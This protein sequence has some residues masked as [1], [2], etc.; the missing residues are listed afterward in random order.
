MKTKVVRY[1]SISPLF[2]ISAI[3]YIML[4]I[5]KSSKGVNSSMTTDVGLYLDHCCSS[6]FSISLC[7]VEVTRIHSTIF[8]QNAWKF[9]Y[10][11]KSMES[12]EDT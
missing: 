8:L 10:N 6:D 7:I 5:S 2:Y 11:R 9:T 12:H 3:P 1:A 4:S